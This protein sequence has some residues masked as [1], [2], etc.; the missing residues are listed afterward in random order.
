M[1]MF[2]RFCRA[3][4]LRSVYNRAVSSAKICGKQKRR[5]LGRSFMHIK[6]KSGLKTE[7]WGTSCFTS[8]VGEFLPP[9]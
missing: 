1:Y 6:N 8:L 2:I 3:L 9:T 7:P 5:E 4:G